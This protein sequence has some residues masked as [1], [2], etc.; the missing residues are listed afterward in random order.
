MDTDKS[1]NTFFQEQCEWD[2]S[3][4][5][6]LASSIIKYHQYMT[7][8]HI[9]RDIMLYLIPSVTEEKTPQTAKKVIP[10]QVQND[11]HTK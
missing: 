1:I 5:N 8:H 10:Q 6:Q 4:C 9:E 3:Y 11:V 7:Q 2:T